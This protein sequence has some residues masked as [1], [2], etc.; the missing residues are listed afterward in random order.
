MHL[1]NCR[2]WEF[3]TKLLCELPD[4]KE[5]KGIIELLD[6][7]LKKGKKITEIKVYSFSCP[8]NKA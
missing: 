8:L 6:K 7:W 1:L 3:N 5:K 4:N 2:K